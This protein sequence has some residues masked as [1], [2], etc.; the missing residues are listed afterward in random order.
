MRNGCPARST[1]ARPLGSTA[2]GNAVAA[3]G[4][5]GGVSDRQ[6]VPWV[7]AVA[8]VALVVPGVAAG[9]ADP[10]AGTEHPVSTWHRTRQRAITVESL[11]GDM[12]VGPPARSGTRTPAARV[13]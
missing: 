5:S 11:A 10:A 12:W 1:S 4:G 3:G 7:V 6:S 2:R 9:S 13:E 8:P